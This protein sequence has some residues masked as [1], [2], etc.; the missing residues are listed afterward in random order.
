MFT[1][2][3]LPF[4]LPQPPLLSSENA[5]W[6]EIQLA[7]FRE[8]PHEIPKYRSQYHTICI[9]LGSSV[10]LEQCIEGSSGE[11]HSSWGDMSFYN[12]NFWQTFRWNRETEFLQLYLEPKFLQQI[13]NEMGITQSL[14]EIQLLASSDKLVLQMALAL[15]N[16]LEDGSG[17]K[18]YA[19]S[20]TRSLGIHLLSRDRANNNDRTSGLSQKQIRQ[21]TEYICDR[22]SV[23]VRLIAYHPISVYPS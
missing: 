8:P 10:T 9:N 1:I 22:V 14:E 7:I 13:S 23:A 5:G 18:L 3:R 2:D 15:K 12:A 20:M 21:V 4:V 19:T 17:C 16:S 11:A 6:E